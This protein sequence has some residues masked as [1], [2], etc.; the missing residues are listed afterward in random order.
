[1]FSYRY[2]IRTGFKNKKKRQELAEKLFS[3]YDQEV[4]SSEV[5]FFYLFIS[6]E[7]IY[8]FKLSN[9]VT[10]VWSGRL[11]ATAGHCTTRRSAQ[12]ATITLSHKVC[13]SPGS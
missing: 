9:K 8:F 13:D 11:T 5:N 2:F 1:L 3:M 6:S 10:L 4:F 7:I 12:T